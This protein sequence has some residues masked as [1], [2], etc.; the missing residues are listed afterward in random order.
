MCLYVYDMCIVS[1]LKHYDNDQILER[2]LCSGQTVSA[3][4]SSYLR[5]KH[6]LDMDILEKYPFIKQIYLKFNCIKTSEAIMERIFCYA[7]LLLSYHKDILDQFSDFLHFI[8]H[9]KHI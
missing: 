3:E 4:I 7:G 9:F 6:S 2:E 1:L 5:E 8:L